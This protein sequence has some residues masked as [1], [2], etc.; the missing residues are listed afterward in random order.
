MNSTI[1]ILILVVA[2]VGAAAILY[3]AQK[4]KTRNLQTK[5]GPEYDR[6]VEI[7]NRS[8]AESELE[9]REKRVQKFRIH[10]LSPD[11]ITQ[12]AEAWRAEQ[13]RFVDDPRGAVERA[14]ALVTQVMTAR[15]YPM[16][17]FEQR[18]ADVS[19]AHPHVVE[20]YR[21]AHDIAQ[22]AAR[23]EISTEELRGALL[24]YRAL[25]ED[26]LEE[27]V[28]ETERLSTEVRR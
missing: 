26:L 3:F 13:A 5:F 6:L 20:H 10:P 25:F 22:R 23:G 14:D 21:A 11:Q 27:R 19:V 18:T 9:R 8:R 16:T 7:G 12:F 15:G 4:Q 1:I 2:V 17:E 24:H 28:I